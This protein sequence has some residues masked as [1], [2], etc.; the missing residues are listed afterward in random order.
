MVGLPVAGPMRGM[1]DQPLFSSPFPRRP[2]PD[3]PPPPDESTPIFIVINAGSVGDAKDGTLRVIT[4][5]LEDAGR[6]YKTFVADR[7]A[8]LGRIAAQAV[9]EAA[10]REGGAVV[11]AVGGDGTVNTV[12]QA[13]L[14]RAR[15]LPFA[16]IPQGTFNYFARVHGISLDLEEATRQLLGARPRP[17]QAGLV[18]GKLFLVNASVGL[19]PQL[20]EDREAWKRKL[21]RSRVVAFIAGLV[22]LLREHPPL[23]I[24]VDSDSA[25]SLELRTPNLFVGNNAMQLDKLGF[26]GQELLAGG[27]L[28]ALTPGDIGTLAMFGLFLRG[29]MGRLGEAEAVTSL[30]FRCLIVRRLGSPMPHHR[31][32]TKV[33]TDGEVCWLE[34]PLR[35][36]TSPRPLFLLKPEENDG[37]GPGREAA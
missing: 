14:D 11:A 10:K 27:R 9:S 15:P 33:A 34:T 19:Y 4:R 29:V 23:R 36:E 32:C 28:V 24:R 25:D 8:K 35:F 20:L 31:G 37:G 17:V 7:A 3:H 5:V 16:V 6:P 2:M 13:L 26:P 1:P 30:P 22:S 18:N 12:A 21:G